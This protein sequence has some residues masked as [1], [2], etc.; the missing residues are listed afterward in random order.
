M[1]K[2][3][4][5]QTLESVDKMESQYLRME[6]EGGVYNFNLWIPEPPE[7]QVKGNRYS[8]LQNV[9][10]DEDFVRPGEDVM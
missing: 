9:H 6:R 4:I 3:V 10:E 1:P 5:S 8:L 7:S 2:K